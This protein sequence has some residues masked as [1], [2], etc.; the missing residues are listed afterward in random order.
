M[1]TPAGKFLSSAFWDM[2]GI[3]FINYFEKGRSIN[4]KYHIELLVCLKEE[5]AKKWPQMKKKKVLFHQDNALR[6]KLITT[7]AKLHQLHFEQ[8]LHVPYSPD[9]IPSDYWLLADL[10]RMLQGKRV[11]SNEE[12]ILE[13]EV[14]FETRDKLFYKKGIKL[15]KKRWNQYITLEEDYVDE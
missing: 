12:V 9:L 6:H 7:M 1:Q 15:L 13:I 2:Q 3:L 4:S 5:I 10:K 14:Y 8:L 11:G